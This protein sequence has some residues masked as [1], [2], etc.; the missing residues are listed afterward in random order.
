MSASYGLGQK[1]TQ[2]IRGADKASGH[3]I[4]VT[5]SGDSDFAPWIGAIDC[6]C[7][8]HGTF[9]LKP[10]S[11]G[12]SCADRMRHLNTRAAAALNAI[13]ETAQVSS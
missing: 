10:V 2:V 4:T 6:E 12:L 1:G 9:A 8:A 13:H 3:A 7:G 5:I 11:V